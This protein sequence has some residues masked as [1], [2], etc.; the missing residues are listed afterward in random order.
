MERYCAIATYSVSG[1][2]GGRIGRG[3]IGN[4][5]PSELVTNCLS[6]DSG[7]AVVDS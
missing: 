6:V 4:A 1:S 7:I 5:V 2:I 3:G